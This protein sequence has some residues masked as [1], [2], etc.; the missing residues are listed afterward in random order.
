[1][2]VSEQKGWDKTVVAKIGKLEIIEQEKRLFNLLSQGI[3]VS[4]ASLI[5]NHQKSW[6]AGIVSK[7]ITELD[8]PNATAVVSTLI[9]KG[10]I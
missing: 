2:T 7:Y 3:K 10:I 5:L 4:T 8:M 9:R 1:M 6:G